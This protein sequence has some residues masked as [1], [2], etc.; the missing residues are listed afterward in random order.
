M[1]SD[2]VDRAVD[3]GAEAVAGLRRSLA[4]RTAALIRSDPDAA[5][6]A[7]EMGLVDARWLEDPVAHPNVTSPPGQVL[8]R[9]L[10]R[11]VESR[12]SRLGTLGLGTVQLL[13]ALGSG[14]GDNHPQHVAVVFTDLEGFTAFTDRQGDQAAVEVLTG[15]QR[16][17][18]AAVRRSGG[19]IVKHIG[20]GLMCT[21][22]TANAAV[23]GAIDLV[24]TGPRDLRVRAGAHSG[25]A[26]LTRTD[27]IG[28]VVNVA[29]RVA[30]E[31]SGGQILAT[32]ALVAD[33]GPVPGVAYGEG[34]ARR[35]K[36]VSELTVICEVL[37]GG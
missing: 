21:F 25:L 23:R 35:L 24:D 1:V 11:A 7:L 29:A 13:T 31:A 22:P 6:A 15:H 2:A 33:A 10:E 8:E 3:T 32:G 37:V 17:A 19:R 28:H 9:F 26:V 12:P 27:M 16:L 20:D 34:R 30:E 36:G 14:R 5:S 18:G 4:R